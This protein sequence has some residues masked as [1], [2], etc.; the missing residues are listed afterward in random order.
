M[1]KSVMVIMLVCIVL[2]SGCKQ[3]ATN[4]YSPD[5]VESLITA[6]YA[7]LQGRDFVVPED[8][9][10]LALPVLRHRVQLSSEKELEGVGVEHVIRQ[11]MSKIEI[12]R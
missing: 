11:L 1:N 4:V 12:P 5:G 7:A 2:L 3:Q 10:Y 8:V 9:I 6:A